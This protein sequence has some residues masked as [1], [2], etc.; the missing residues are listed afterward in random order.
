MARKVNVGIIGY[1]FM[2]K[3]HSFGY[4]NM[5]M[6]CDCEAI[7]V[8]KAICGRKEEGVRAAAERYGWESYETDWRKL[9][10]REDIDVVDVPSSGGWTRRSPVLAPWGT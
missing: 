2:G 10:A 1:S 6:F 7:P 4:K 5:P 9:V 8:M 3:A